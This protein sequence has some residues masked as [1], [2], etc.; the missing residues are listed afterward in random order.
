MPVFVGYVKAEL[1]GV[2]L[3]AVRT[4]PDAIFTIDVKNGMSDEVREGVTISR[5]DE[6]ELEGSRGVSNLVLRFADSTEKASCSLLTAEDFKTKFKKKKQALAEA[7]R[8][9]TADDSG[10]WVPVVAFEGRGMDV[11]KLRLTADDV[12]VTSTGDA[13]FEDGVDLS[14]GDWADYDAEAD[15]SVSITNAQTKVELVR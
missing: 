3:A 11:V 1:D 5:A 7:P 2:A 14:D 6:F 8:V 9:L 13:V 15:V 12:V 10:E 4:G